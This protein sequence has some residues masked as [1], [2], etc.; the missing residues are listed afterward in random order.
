VITFDGPN[1]EILLPPGVGVFDTI[2]LWSRWIDWVHSGVGAP[3]PPAF[4]SIGG[5]E[6]GTGEVPFFLQLQN[7]T[8]DLPM[9][10]W[11]IRLS[12][13]SQVEMSGNLIPANST[14]PTYDVP[15][16]SSLVTERTNQAVFLPD[17]TINNIADRVWEELQADHRNAGTMGKQQQ[18]QLNAARIAAAN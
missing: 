13:N 11:V 6:A 18:H 9:S 10:G 1:R 16:S 8:D 3:F 17:S 15:A 14:L 12:P 5:Q 2:E 4:V 7:Q